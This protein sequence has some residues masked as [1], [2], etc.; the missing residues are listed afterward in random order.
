MAELEQK[1][2]DNTKSDV[3][4]NPG[5]VEKDQLEALTPDASRPDTPIQPEKFQA[6][7]DEEGI[8]AFTLRGAQGGSAEKPKKIAVL[9][10]GGDSA[11]MNAAGEY[12]DLSLQPKHDL[13]NRICLV[14]QSELSSEWV[15][16]EVVT[17]I[18]FERGG[19]V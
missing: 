3:A 7:K 1:T 8:P 11:G 14:K 10:S 4:Q 13:P 19:K 16:H 17:H 18:S 15:S 12:C 9:T 2:I 6:T 5:H